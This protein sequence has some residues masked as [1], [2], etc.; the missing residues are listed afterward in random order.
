MAFQT[1]AE[2]WHVDG[3]PTF[4]F[5]KEGKAVDR[6]VGAKKDDLSAFVEKH[7]VADAVAVS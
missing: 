7:A 5:L 2:E 6:I 4:L 1:V 3:M